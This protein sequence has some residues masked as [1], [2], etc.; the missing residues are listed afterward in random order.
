MGHSK[1][2]TR[3]QPEVV[4]T[5]ITAIHEGFTW[6]L[7][8]QGND[9]WLAVVDNLAEVRRSA[10]PAPCNCACPCYNKKPYKGN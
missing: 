7:T 8:P 1:V 9:Y 3:L 2:D 5:A 6:G 10:G 4:N